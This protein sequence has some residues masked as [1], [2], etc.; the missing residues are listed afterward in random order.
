MRMRRT[1]NNLR[2]RRSKRRR[3]KRKY[4]IGGVRI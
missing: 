1:T 2:L 4:K 3:S